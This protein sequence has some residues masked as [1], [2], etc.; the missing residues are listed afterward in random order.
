LTDIQPS[1]KF[2]KEKVFPNLPRL[3][4]NNK[5]DQFLIYN[6]FKNDFN[7]KLEEEAETYAPK[8]MIYMRLQYL[9]VKNVK[10]IFKTIQ[11]HAMF[12]IEDGVLTNVVLRDRNNNILLKDYRRQNEEFQRRYNRCC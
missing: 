3:E 6:A 12:K 8:E 1:F 2:L 9:E 11:Q 5:Q 4:I 7:R 10:E